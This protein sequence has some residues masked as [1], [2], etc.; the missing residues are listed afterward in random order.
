MARGADKAAK[1]ELLS[2]QYLRG[3]AAAL[4]VFYHAR[5]QLPAAKALIDTQIGLAGVDL[6]FVISG[7]VMTYTTAVQPIS[8]GAFLARRAARIVPLYWVVTAFLAVLLIT[9]PGVFNSSVFTWPSF[10]QSLF[11]IPHQNPGVL[12]GVLPMLK[13]GWTLNYEVLFYLVFA[14]LIALPPARRTALMALLFAV[15]VAAVAI[16]DPNSIP[17]RFWGDSIIFEFIFGCIVGTLFLNGGL[18][19]LPRVLWAAVLVLAILALVA[20]SF[21]TPGLLRFLVWGL[22]CALIA[23][24][25]IALEQ[26]ATAPWRNRALHFLGDAS[27]SIYLV[28]AYIVVAFR[29]LWT[30]FG[31]PMAGWA[32][33]VSFI[34]L[35]MFA[36][37]AA[38]CVTYLLIERPLT[39]AARRLVPRRATAQA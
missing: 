5:D 31:L 17:L 9:A 19:K 35:C 39:N 27:Y 18:K 25:A 14:G 37:I 8:A 34:A 3:I 2:V 4:V 16:L 38:G 29:I 28:H 20:A 22:P 10:F 23:M 26:K 21:E 30:Q 32:A 11:F 12:G 33:V 7:F 24:A 1:T 6:F 13:L 15:L 36:G